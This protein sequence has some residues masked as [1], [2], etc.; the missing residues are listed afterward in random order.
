MGETRDY[1]IKK[2]GA[3]IYIKASGEVVLCKGRGRGIFA[4]FAPRKY[5]YLIG[6][7]DFETEV[8]HNMVA[9]RTGHD[10]KFI[11]IEG[12]GLAFET[13]DY[14]GKAMKSDDPLAN[15]KLI[16]SF[17]GGAIFD[18]FSPRITDLFKGRRWERIRE[19]ANMYEYSGS[20][21]EGFCPARDLPI[22]LYCLDYMRYNGD[23]FH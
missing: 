22:L 19:S 2:V 12:D 10:R 21:M 5:S 17:H 4:P 15:P 8:S 11:Y 23:G 6:D 14:S 13:E 18:Y 3:D 9:I 1:F 20:L 7:E 16:C